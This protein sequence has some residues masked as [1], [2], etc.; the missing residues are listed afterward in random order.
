MTLIKTAMDIFKLLNKSNCRAC[1][2]KTCLAFAASVF[3]GEK[4]IDEC[5]HLDKNVIEKYGKNIERPKTIQSEQEKIIESLK[6]EISKIDLSS[7]AK[8]VGGIFL[9][10]KLTLKVFGKDFSIDS[11][12]SLFSDIH[13]NP[14]VT[15]PLL[16]YILN[17]HGEPIT[18]KWMPFRE[19]KGGRER[20]GLF[21]QQCEKPL[22][23]IADTY[24]DFFEDLMDIFNGKKEK[25]HYDSD[26]AISLYPLPKI[27]ILIC[28]WKPD[29]EL[30][31]DFN[32]F[33]D[34]TAEKNCGI[35]G[36]YAL[37]TG[38]VRM[39]EKLAM[40]HAG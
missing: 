34:F 27:P 24:T 10:D 19:L 14:W 38:I 30:A 25:N 23:R 17:C 2:E 11:K 28:Y 4:R 31:S 8:R 6:M 12:G 15:I 36:V 33:F 20:Q 26:I 37:G 32:L 22:K 7:A 16:N 29:A 9:N 5:P 18:G 35:G 1:N 21:G 3:K 40:R 39:F 13:V